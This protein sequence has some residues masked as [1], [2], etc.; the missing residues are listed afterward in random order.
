MAIPFLENKGKP[1]LYPGYLYVAGEAAATR[2]V[3]KHLRRVRHLPAESHGVIGYWR[4]NREDWERR[5]RESGVDVE[6]L[7]AQAQAAGRDEEEALDL[8]ESRLAEVGLL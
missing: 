1:Y 5:R 3:R 2:A 7:Y 4:R 8:Y 6:Q